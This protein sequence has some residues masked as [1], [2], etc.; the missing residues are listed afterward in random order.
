MHLSFL[1]IAYVIRSVAVSGIQQ[2]FQSTNKV[3][4]TASTAAQLNYSDRQKLR[5]KKE[6][7]LDDDEDDNEPINIKTRYY[8]LYLIIFV[9]Y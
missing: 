6:V 3:P 9:V 5:K 2:F 1:F 4:F 7:V 8:S